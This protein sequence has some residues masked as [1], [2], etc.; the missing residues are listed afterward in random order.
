[1]KY[2]RLIAVALVGTL[3]FTTAIPMAQGQSRYDK[4]ANLPFKEGFIA[5]D[6]DQTP[7]DDACANAGR[8]RGRCHG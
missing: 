8:G 4:L 2:P 1:M 6:K 3:A 5:K 7:L